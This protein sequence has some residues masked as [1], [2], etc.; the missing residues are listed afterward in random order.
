M[1]QIEFTERLKDL[2]LEIFTVADAVRVSGGKKDSVY[3]F[4][5][6]LAG[7]R[8][9]IRIEKGKY[10]L[11]GVEPRIAATNLI[12]PSYISFIS[13]L[14][15]HGRSSQ[16]PREIQVVTSTT[17]RGIEYEGYAVRFVRFSPGRLFGYE[18]RK[19]H[20][21]PW[22]I[23]ELEKVIVDSLYLPRYCPVS[24]CWSAMRE[25]I[26]AEKLITYARRM[27]SLVTLK[28]ACYLL[29]QMGR[30]VPEKIHEVIS[31]KYD[32]LNPLLPREGE[33]DRHW[34]LIINEVL[35]DA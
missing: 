1:K 9:I 22:F 27:A 10:A 23:G 4:L 32:P 5:S 6:R 17:K 12:F 21:T 26:D 15:H 35:N 19:D 7:R 29:E 30:D 33:R 13:G 11:K 14:Y 34:R 20:R 3:L 28:R 16:M 24:E 8:Q 31:K 18:R 25:G 2:G